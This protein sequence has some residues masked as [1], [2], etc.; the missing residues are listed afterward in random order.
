MGHINFVGE[1][2]E[3]IVQVA[4]KYGFDDLTTKTTQEQGQVQTQI[5]AIRDLA[6]QTDAKVGVIMGSDSV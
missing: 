3:Q 1:T 4:G 6:L 2:V 5:H